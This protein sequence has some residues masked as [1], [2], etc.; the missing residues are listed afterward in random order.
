MCFLFHILKS[1]VI[2]LSFIICNP[3]RN[4]NLCNKAQNTVNV[5]YFKITSDLGHSDYENQIS[6]VFFRFTVQGKRL[7]RL[8]RQDSPFT[9]NGGF[10]KDILEQ[11][12]WMKN[13]I[14]IT[15]T[16]INTLYW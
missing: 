10:L 3:A 11:L 7:T 8:D 4:F 5:F 16:K 6:F 14:C 9:N 13:L 15:G 2:H 1:T 12:L